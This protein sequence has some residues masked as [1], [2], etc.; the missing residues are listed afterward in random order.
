[1]PVTSTQCQKNKRKNII[2]GKLDQE[3]FA[4]VLHLGFNFPLNTHKL[5]YLFTRSFK[6]TGCY[7]INDDNQI[8]ITIK[9]KRLVNWI[10]RNRN[11]IIYSK[12][13]LRRKWLDYDHQR[14]FRQYDPRSSLDYYWI[15]KVEDIEDVR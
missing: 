1:M 4:I 10:K 9:K 14:T 2:H 5:N 13:E 7:K 3:V 12:V 8:E 6:N 15:F 11:R